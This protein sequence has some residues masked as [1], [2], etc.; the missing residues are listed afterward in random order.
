[1]GAALARRGRKA[2]HGKRVASGRL[3]RAGMVPS[4]DQ[5]TER[6]KAMQALYGPDGSDAIGRAYRAGLLGEG[7]EAK[8]LLDTARRIANAYWQAYATGSYKCP[9]GES[10]HGGAIDLDHERI[11]RREEWLR[12]SLEMVHRMGLRTQFDQLCIDVNPDSGPPWLDELI[13]A[14][15]TRAEP[16]PINSQRLALAL[17][18]LAALV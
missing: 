2:K 8:A 17:K 11:K 6:T 7:T 15:R 5:G 14:R 1:M 16:H 4:F 9:L 10:T 18:A 3:S 12:D 13:Y